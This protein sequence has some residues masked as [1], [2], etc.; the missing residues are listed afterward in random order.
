MAAYENSTTSGANKHSQLVTIFTY[1][2]EPSH[3]FHS[4]GHRQLITQQLNNE[5]RVERKPQ[6]E[7]I[8][9][10]KAAYLE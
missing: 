3:R 6:T 2:K 5:K 7:K 4:T 10:R 8:Y 9:K 1:I